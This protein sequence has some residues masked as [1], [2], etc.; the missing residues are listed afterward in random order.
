MVTRS[1]ANSAGHISD[2]DSGEYSE[3]EYNCLVPNLVKPSRADLQL[4]TKSADQPTAYQC[5]PGPVE[6]LVEPELFVV[7]EHQTSDEQAG[8]VEL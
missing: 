5:E 4:G 3:E 7:R 2:I 1:V 8:P 6:S